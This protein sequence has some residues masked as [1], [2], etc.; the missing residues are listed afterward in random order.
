MAPKVDGQE[1]RLA[2]RVDWLEC[3]EACLPGKA[4]LS[5]SLPVRAKAAAGAQAVAIATAR[6]QLPVA[7]PAWRFTA[8]PGPDG[9]QLSVRPPR[10]TPRLRG[11]PLPARGEG[12]RA[13]EAAGPREGGERLP[14][15]VGA[16]GRR[17]PAA[18]PAGSA[19]GAHA[20]G[21]AGPRGGRAP[22]GRC[23]GR[24]VDSAD[25]RQ[26]RSGCREAVP[27]PPRRRQPRL[28][29]R[30]GDDDL[31]PRRVPEPLLRRAQ[32]LQPRDGPDDPRRV[33]RRRRRRD[34]DEHLRRAPLQARPARARGA[35]RARST[36]RAR[37]SRAR[38]RRGATSSPA[39]SVRS[40]SRS[41]R[42]AT[43]GRRRRARPGASRPRGWSRAVST[44]SCSRRCRRSTR[45][46]VALE[47]VRSVSSELP[48]GVSLT[49][50]EEGNTIYGDRPEDALR[51]LEA[52]G[53]PR[54]G[55]NCARARRRC[56]RRSS[57]WPR[58]RAR[59]RCPRCPTPAPPA[60]VEGRYVYLCTPE[61]MSTLGAPLPRLRRAGRRRLLR[62][63]PGPHPRPR[64]R[65]AQL[66]PSKAEVRSVPAQRPREAPAPMPP[67]GEVDARPQAGAQVRGLRRDRP[68]ARG[69]PRRI[70]SSARSTARRT[71]STRSTSRTA[72]GPRRA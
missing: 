68:A 42:S 29:R 22:G 15:R 65:G 6:G 55:A 47:A 31:R 57:A 71:R 63:H 60:L 53:V 33:P 70:S 1:L 48:V 54:V 21:G 50:N 24:A 17:V 72:R 4:E 64:A 5:L 37:G 2:V 62:H 40:A 34:R 25:A 16:R 19:R 9:L 67:R 28:R 61:Y 11:L 41:R 7:D 46:L 10:G 49:F 32:P 27:R 12:R 26:A 52:R 59:R 58:S 13:R 35:G 23:S 30:D 43:C 14:A 39:R 51:E 56:S 18:A 3:Q 44:C 69:R 8:T 45:P 20:G 38:R 36:A 66:R